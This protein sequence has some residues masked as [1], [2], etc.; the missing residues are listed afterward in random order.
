MTNGLLLAWHGP[1][2]PAWT[3]PELDP[4]G[5]AAPSLR[6]F[7]LRDHPQETTENSVDLG[8]FGI[9][10]GYRNVRMARDPVT[11]GPY[12]STSFALE[13]DFGETPAV[14]EEPLLAP[15]GDPG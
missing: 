5:W 11:D 1:G 14:A 9:V 15:Q 6:Q 12:L 8:H 3:V 2:P 10:H 13:H 7:V 4:D